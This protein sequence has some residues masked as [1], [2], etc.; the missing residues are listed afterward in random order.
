MKLFF[1]NL[2]A[3]KHKGE[4]DEH[5]LITIHEPLHDTSEGSEFLNDAIRMVEQP[6]MYNEENLAAERE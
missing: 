1:L 3:K 4:P 2:P 5:M 6:L